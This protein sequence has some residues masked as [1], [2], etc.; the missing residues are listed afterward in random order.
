MKSRTVFNLSAALSAL[1]F[2]S[3]SGAAMAQDAPQ[4][5]DEIQT[6]KADIVVTGVRGSVEAAATKKKNSKQIVDSVVAEDAG[7]LPDNNVPEALS[8][9]TGVQIDRARGQGQNVTIR[10][11]S[12]VQTTINGN[13]VNLG[14]DRAISLADIPAELLKSVDVYKTRTA[15]QVEGGI[16]GTV[17]VQLRRPLDLKKGLTVA[18][19]LRGAYDEY[20]KKTSPYASLLLGERFETGMGEMGF[21]LNGSWTRTYYQENYVESE[22]PS[23]VCCEGLAGSPLNNLPAQY[24]NVVIPYRT[25]YGT[26]GGNVTRPSLN[27]VFQWKPSDALEF[28]LEGSYIGSKERR[29]IDKMWTLNRE[30]G[31]Q[32]SGIELM[33]DG[34]TIKKLTISNPNGVP[35][36]IEGTRNTLKRDLY[37]ANFETNWR[38]SD[39]ALLH[40]STQYSWSKDSY[41][42]VQQILR[43]YN[44][45]SATIDF[46]SDAY[47][48]P[49]PSITL[50][51]IDLNDVTQYGVN[52]FQDNSGESKNKEI[53]S[54]LDLTLTLSDNDFLR[55][56]QTGVRYN[57]RNVDRYYGY[58]DGFPRVGGRDAPLTAFPGG[59]QAALIGPDLS[60]SPQWY[61]VPGNVLL[62]NIDAVR[63]YIQATNPGNAA[64]F[65]SE[66]PPADQGQTF[67]S[68]ENTFAAYAQLNY[69][70][71][72]GFPIDGVVGLRAVNTWG[73]STSFQYQI[74]APEQGFPLLI[75]ES[76]GRGN[77]MDYLP[78][79]TATLHFDPKTQL[80]LSYTT[81]VSRPSFYSLRPFFFVNPNAA[82]PRVDAGN[83]K[84]KA[85]REW[86]L[87]ASLEHY[88]GK[89]GSASVAG[90]YKKTT[91]WTYYSNEIVADLGEYGLPGRSGS[92]A[93]LRNAGDGTFYGV[94]AQVQ[95]FFDFLP[96]A[97]KNFGASL[98]VTRI[99]QARVEY[100]Y[101]EAFP[102]AFDALDT[103]KWTANAALYY[104]TPKFSTRVA[105]N[106][107]SPYRLFVWT[108]NPAY[109][110]YN[111]ATHRL[112]A[113]VNYTPVPFM[114][115]SIEGTNLTGNDPYRYF[116]KENILP[117]GVRTMART[118]QGSIRFRF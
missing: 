70:F 36:F 16:A 26:E 89:A 90:Y 63:A 64:R 12:Q 93:Q 86:S 52:R 56:L 61:R 72:V 117:L 54:Q 103:S 79:I 25:Q 9:V 83:P 6:A 46:V 58:R 34:Q 82:N 45:Q 65:A 96:G 19:S 15:D 84:L 88:F 47:S 71:D 44:L 91:N 85:Q 102:G 22:S 112:D 31:T 66:L 8:R 111:D 78:S 114:T 108:D 30:F 49:I 68:V 118:V 43:P 101:P 42:Y 28:I 41:Y 62:S 17:N 13:N 94:E 113:A 3:V 4:S 106:Y 5:S 97:L 98:N 20:A 57:R 116:G 21:L 99:L 109:S 92:V 24:R 73:S 53:A 32:F 95:S 29:S 14:T 115:L 7:K 55:S 105:F 39:R 74:G 69:E 104:D 23:T 67:T 87:N 2:A 35:A 1:A 50:N 38:P 77:F 60:G 81:N 80:R 27:G 75:E 40:F 59:D 18:G 11:L 37:S 110:W 100:P 51:G 107:R 10:G 48:R 76:S 33:P